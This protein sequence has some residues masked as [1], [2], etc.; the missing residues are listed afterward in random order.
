MYYLHL[1]VAIVQQQFRQLGNQPNYDF[2]VDLLLYFL[3]QLH[4]HSMLEYQ[5]QEKHH[6]SILYVEEFYDVL[7]VVVVVDFD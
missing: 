2:V 6:H 5:V 4:L 7:S 1:V 3:D